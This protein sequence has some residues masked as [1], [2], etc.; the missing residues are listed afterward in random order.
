MPDE[1]VR[2]ALFSTRSTSWSEASEPVDGWTDE[3]TCVATSAHS[4]RFV[5][6]NRGG[7]VARAYE[8]TMQSNDRPIVKLVGSATCGVEGRRLASAALSDD[9]AVAAFGCQPNRTAL[10]WHPGKSSGMR[11]MDTGP[12]ADDRTVDTE[13]GVVAFAGPTTSA[14]SLAGHGF[15]VCPLGEPPS[16]VMGTLPSDK[17]TLQRYASKNK[18]VTHS[19]DEQVVGMHVGANQRWY[20]WWTQHH[21]SVRCSAGHDAF[22]VDEAA[23]VDATVTD[24]C[25]AFLDAARVVHVYDWRGVVRFVN[26][27]SGR[28]DDD[29]KNAQPTTR[30]VCQ[31]ATCRARARWHA[32]SR[33]ALFFTQDG[34]E[35]WLIDQAGEVRRSFVYQQQ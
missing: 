2:V 1:S 9:G 25:Y 14:V 17:V 34:S 5:A 16:V 6:V 33:G 21:L 26:V 24:E 10:L 32:A 20:A 28:S 35:L 30:S 4:N 31:C 23:V 18:T 13:H 8:L 7:N 22:V 12:L 19:L 27:P 3:P 29:E 15:L 11:P